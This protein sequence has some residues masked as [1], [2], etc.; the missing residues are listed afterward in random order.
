MS[1][2]GGTPW[3]KDKKD[4]WPGKGVRDFF[5]ESKRYYLA[6]DIPKAIEILEWGKR[7]SLEEGSGGAVDRFDDMIEKLRDA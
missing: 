1:L 4:G 7:F 6:D 2:F 5:D 3:W